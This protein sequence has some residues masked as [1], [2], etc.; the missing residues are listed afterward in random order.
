MATDELRL[1][2]IALACL[3][4]P[5]GRALADLVAT[6][7]PAGALAAVVDGS[8][9]PALVEAAASRL[10]AADPRLI[11]RGTGSRIDR[12]TFP[13]T[14]LWVRGRWPLAETLEHSVAVVGSR[15]ATA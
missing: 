11:S 14:C 7:G 5:G 1:A 3:F 13:P 4:E 15:A 6:A 12:D 8:A 9:E 10:P 2:R